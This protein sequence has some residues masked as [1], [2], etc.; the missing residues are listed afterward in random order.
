M[1]VAISGYTGPRKTGIG[2]TLENILSHVSRF[3]LNGVDLYLFKNW[4]ME[5]LSTP[6]GIKVLPIQVSKRSSIGNLLWH[7][8]VYPARLLFMRAD[9]SYIPNVTLLL[10][11]PC[12]TVVVIHDLIEFNVP[13]KFSRA[14]MVYRK[15]AVPITARRA[16]RII[17]VSENT[18]R[19]LVK[20]LKVPE[21]KIEVVYNGVDPRFKPA[22][23]HLV[24]EVRAKY[25]LPSKYI[26]FV[27]TIDHP[28]KNA[29]SLVE[30][31]AA[32]WSRGMLQ[33]HHLVLV[34]QKGFGYEQIMH[35]IT[36]LGVTE[37]VRTLGY[38]GDADLPAIYTGADVFAFLSLYEGFGLPIL[39]A[40]ACGTPV[41]A[42]KTSCLPEICGDAALLVDPYDVAGIANAIL[43]LSS[44][45]QLRAELSAKGL[46]RVKAFSWER[47]ARSTLEVLTR[48]ARGRGSKP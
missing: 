45:R 30:A 2:R 10:F 43:R 23:E 37:R 25:S 46:E 41:V 3:D 18:K 20:L 48:T 21:S 5:E 27:G 24:R 35:R 11:K 26:L 16:D 17:T 6:S 7:Q 19:D 14:R 28:G 29:M 33:E 15:L 13:N 1:R 47:A 34:G 9:V 40:M 8:F 39:E 22:G 36:E 12:P 38:V 44:E 4:D 31:C 42:A 32:L